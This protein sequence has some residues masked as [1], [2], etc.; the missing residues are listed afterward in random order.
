MLAPRSL[1]LV[2]MLFAAPFAAGSQAKVNPVEKVIELLKKIRDQIQEE[3]KEEAIGYDKFACFCKDQSGE[4][5]AIIKKSQA[6]IEKMDAEIELLTTEIEEHDQAVVDDRKKKDDLEKEGEEAAKAREEVFD[7]YSENEKDM[8]KA[9]KAIEGAIEALELSKGKMS[10]AKLD[11]FASKQT[12][13]KIADAGKPRSLAT[14]AIRQVLAL[15]EQAPAKYEYASNDIIATLSGLLK[16]FKKDKVDL[17]NEEAGS[18]Q[19]YEMEKGARDFKIKSLGDL[20]E[21][22]TAMSASKTEKKSQIEATL[23][24]ETDMKNKDEAFLKELTLLCEDK[25]KAWDERSKMRASEITAITE[26][27]GDLSTGVADNYSANKKLTLIVPKHPAM[28]KVDL[29]HATGPVHHGLIVDDDGEQLESEA[30][31]DADEE[32]LDELEGYDDDMHD[33]PSFVQ[34]RGAQ[35]PKQAA[36]GRR[37]AKHAAVNYLMN[38]AKS[39]KSKHLSAIVAKLQ[40]GKDHFVKVR[41]IIKDL[42]AKLEA[43]AEAEAT[44]KTYCDE[45]MGKAT[46]KRDDAVAAIEDH[47]ASIDATESKIANLKDSIAS[48]ETEIAELFKSKKEITE[49]REAEKAENEKTIKDAEEGGKS[50]ANAIKI[51][52][53]FYGESFVQASFEPEGGDRDGNTVADLAPKT[54]EGE[55]R[56][57]KDSTGGIFGLLEIIQADFERTVETVK[58]AETKSQEEFEKQKKEIEDSIDEKKEERTTMK[59]DL[60]TEESALVG[61]QEDLKD[62][63]VDLGDAKGELEKLKPLCVDTGM[64]W[65]ARRE[66]AKQEVEALKEALAILEDWKK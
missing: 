8:S 4:K 53:D 21:Q 10:D 58:A 13:G 30:N 3:G 20:I 24:E 48:I 5:Q 31:V 39:L 61:F 57:G 54:F 44:Q 59:S 33:I 29:S 22:N 35:S 65:K 32:E 62:A 1:Y 50:V 42:I 49:L 26:A 55:Y 23:E 16:T 37:K 66:Q 56:G 40:L 60:E 11:L 15:L 25:A 52:K 2:V 7:E 19:S 14:T 9:I 46:S 43:D 38:K 63:K 28:S 18:R 47:T 45:E 41:S 36:A 64:S 34:L 27:L 51:L 17:D 6:A 12:L